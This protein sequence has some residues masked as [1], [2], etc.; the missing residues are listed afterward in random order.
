M[1]VKTTLAAIPVFGV[2][3][4]DLPPK[5]L[6][7]MVK[8]CHSFLW[9][10]RKEASGGHCL[11]ASDKVS[12]PTLVGGLGIPNFRYMNIAL[13][14]RWLWLRRTEKDKPWVEFDISVP[15]E[16]SAIFEAAT[17]TELRD[18]RSFLF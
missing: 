17:R 8:I 4:L 13:R 1:L 14:T 12:S 16:A 10:G 18:G 5:T 11:V 2:M 7:A 6:A 3:S 15:M 9:V